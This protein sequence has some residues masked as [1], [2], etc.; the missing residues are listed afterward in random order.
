MDKQKTHLSLPD[1]SG[2][3]C[4]KLAALVLEV[5]KHGVQE[6]TPADHH[7]STHPTDVITDDVSQAMLRLLFR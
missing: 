5:I 7:D 1:S 3:F 4:R 2:S 6:A